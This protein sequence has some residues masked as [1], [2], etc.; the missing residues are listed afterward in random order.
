MT[1]T[2]I[3]IFSA[4]AIVMISL[5]TRQSLGIFALPFDELSTSD[6][7]WFGFAIAVQNLLWGLSSPFFGAIADRYGAHKSALLGA[8]LYVCGLLIIADIG[9]WSFF[10]GQVMIGFGLAGCGLSI[11]L[12]AVAK[13]CSE[14]RR[15]FILG[16]VSAAGSFGQFALVPI[17]AH[18]FELYSWFGSFIIL[19]VIATFLI[20]FAFALKYSHTPLAARKSSDQTMRSVLIEARTHKDFILLTLGFFVCG[21]QVVF[22]ATHL[23]AYLIDNGIISTTASYALAL[24]GLFNIFGTL[25]AGWLGGRYRKKTVLTGLYLLRS[26]VILIFIL[27][28]LTPTTAILFGVFIGFLWLGTVPLTSG[29]VA[30]FFDVKHLSLLYGIVFFSHQVGSFLGAWL[31]GLTFEAYGSYM[32]IWI[33]AILFGLVSA[34]LHYPIKEDLPVISKAQ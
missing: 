34:A 17:S 25:F 33:L 12:G 23:T 31:G 28:P 30:Y 19:S 20:P 2:R 5:G 24:I 6:R 4:I 22:I 32:P 29:L 3:V 13:V 14:Q 10:L 16:V 9:Q 11:A 15:S 26:L 7:Q 8:V 1:P 27:V 21:F 18:L